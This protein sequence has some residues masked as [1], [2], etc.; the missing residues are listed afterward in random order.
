MKKYILLCIVSFCM[1]GAGRAQLYVK[2]YTGYAFATGN[3]QATSDESLYLYDRS[4]KTYTAGRY[5]S[6]YLMKMGQGVNI[7][8]SLGYALSKNVAFEITGNTQLFSTF[9]VSRPFRLLDLYNTSE[10]YRDWE[11]WGF[12]G[13]MKYTNMM[14]Q[15]SPQIVFMSN[16]YRQW[17]FYLK[18]GPD[19]IWATHKQ[20]TQTPSGYYSSAKLYTYE[21]SGN[22]NTGIQCSFGA[23]YELSKNMHAF[24]EITTVNVRYTFKK[25]KILRYEIDGE[26]AMSE[27]RSTSFDKLDDKIIFNHAGLNV[28]IKYTFK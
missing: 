15:V 1:S 11:A 4:V 10:Y 2:G 13:D 16:P 28:G 22:I 18:G 9:K 25:S 14:F 21:Y 26:D 20:T 17:T 19:F 3:E 7:G 6:S 5:A 23:E 24:A 12:F 27:L 8:L